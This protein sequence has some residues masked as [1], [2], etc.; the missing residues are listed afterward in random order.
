MATKYS[1]SQGSHRF[2]PPSFWRTPSKPGRIGVFAMFEET[3]LYE[4]PFPD[5]LDYN[6]LAGVSL[7]A[8]TNQENS[9]ILGWRANKAEGV[10]ELTPYFHVR[11]RRIIGEANRAE[12]ITS[13][14]PGEWFALWLE[15]DWRHET[16]EVN[17]LRI[18]AAE[19][20]GYTQAGFRFP[21][22]PRLCRRIGPWFGGNL[23]A[24]HTMALWM[25]DVTIYERDGTPVWDGRPL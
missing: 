11:G 19:Q 3:C 20:V 15:L 24:P 10:L 2:W 5:S 6:K 22:W 9:A 17:V 14:A 25:E 4:H 8:W 21:G 1:V 16:V 23:P 12:P 7:N 13:V 18:A